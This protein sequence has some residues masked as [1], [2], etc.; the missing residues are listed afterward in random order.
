VVAALRLARAAAVVRLLT[1]VA[2]VRP[3][4]R[5]FVEVEGLRCDAALA[6]LSSVSTW[7]PRS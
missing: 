4:A 6:A 7:D 5:F 3:V 2:V 1:E